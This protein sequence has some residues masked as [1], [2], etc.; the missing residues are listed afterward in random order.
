MKKKSF[1]NMQCPI[2]RSL[3]EV[4]EWWSILILRESM[5]GLSRFDDFQKVLDIATNTLTRRLT[6]LVSSGLLEKKLYSEKPP[7]YEYRLTQK[8]KDFRPVILT[9]L[10]WGNKYCAE[11]GLSID[12]VDKETNVSAD[13]TL[14]DKLSGK[15]ITFESHKA[16]LGPAAKE[17]LRRQ[18]WGSAGSI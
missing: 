5:K 13:I 1:S 4:G 8:G 15:E 17:E 7:R 11:E 2:A 12:L 18:Y 3:E 10:A 6:G 14:I 9:L 16:V